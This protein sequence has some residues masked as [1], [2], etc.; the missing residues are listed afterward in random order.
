MEKSS[1][2]FFTELLDTYERPV[3]SLIL[4]I[5][6]NREDAEELSQ[7][8]FMKIYRSLDKFRGESNISTWIYRIAWNTAISFTRVSKHE[9]AD[10]DDNIIENVSD[11]D[12]D[13]EMERLDSE[14]RLSRLDKAME[15]LQPDERALILLFY[16]EEKTVAE[17]ATITGLTVSNVKV[18]IFRIRQKLLVILQKMEDKEYV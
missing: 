5:V 11:S 2:I 12:V 13:S 1:E 15:Q 17:V 14:E 3:F 18:K 4:K 7:D 8:V 16:M 9:S 10:I 6:R